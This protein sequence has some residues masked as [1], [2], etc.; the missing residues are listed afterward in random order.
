[1]SRLDDIKKTIETAAK[2][3]LGELC[4]Q[5]SKHGWGQLS[6]YGCEHKQANCT[7]C[8]QCVNR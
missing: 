4:Y 2:V 7:Y 1:M 6:V 5:S 3:P 8:C